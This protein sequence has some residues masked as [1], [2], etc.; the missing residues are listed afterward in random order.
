[1]AVIFDMSSGTIESVISQNRGIETR[2]STPDDRP[3]PQLAIQEAVTAET[4]T[5]TNP[6]HLAGELL[7]KL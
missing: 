4:H 3:E 2:A 7:K 5:V 6:A 1:M